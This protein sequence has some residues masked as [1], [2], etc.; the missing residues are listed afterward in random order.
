MPYIYYIPYKCEIETFNAQKSTI[1]Y[2]LILLC[3]NTI[4][5][6]GGPLQKGRV[7]NA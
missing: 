2:K 5:L 1:L 7:S 3:C 4:Q 6:S